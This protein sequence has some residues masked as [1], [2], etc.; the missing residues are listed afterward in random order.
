MARFHTNHHG[1]IIVS[2]VCSVFHYMC[3]IFLLQLKGL[4]SFASKLS[5]SKHSFP[6]TQS[7]LYFKLNEVALHVFS[8]VTQLVFSKCNYKQ[9][10]HVYSSGVLMFPNIYYA[11][12]LMVQLPEIIN[13]PEALEY[14]KTNSSLVFP[15]FYLFTYFE[16]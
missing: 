5:S 4:H 3:P 6:I 10:L 8:I 2:V 16:V 15:L 9:L 12:V 7:H 11:A 1:R 14:A 13:L